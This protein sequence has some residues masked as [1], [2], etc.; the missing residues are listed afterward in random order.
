MWAHVDA[1]LLEPPAVIVVALWP[2]GGEAADILLAEG[3]SPG[4]SAGDFPGLS[5][6][7]GPGLSAGASPG[8]SAGDGPGL[9]AGDGPGLSAGDVSD[10]EPAAWEAHRIAA[11]V[12][13]MGAELTDKTIPAE[14]GLVAITASFTKG[15][16][17]GQELVAR[18][19]SRGGNVPRH[20]RRLRSASALAPGDDLT[21]ADGKVVGAVT[22]AAVHP[23]LGVVA[24]GYLARSVAA[25]DPV[26]S[27][28]GPVTVLAAAGAQR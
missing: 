4:L 7:D 22:S 6:G 19:D 12:P 1:P 17:T 14:T 26:V 8:L 27:A 3:A 2:D 25:G 24:L 28:S 23:E 13:V 15:C 11:G 9:S 20:L 5:A 21:N 10:L 18:I 16:Y